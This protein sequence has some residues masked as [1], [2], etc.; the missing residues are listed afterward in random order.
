MSLKQVKAEQNLVLNG[1]SELKRSLTSL[2]HPPLEQQLHENSWSSASDSF[3]KADTFERARKNLEA[4]QGSVLERLQILRERVAT[5]KDTVLT[6]STILEGDEG[7]GN[8]YMSFFTTDGHGC[9]QPFDEVYAL[10]AKNHTRLLGVLKNLREQVVQLP[11]IVPRVT[12]KSSNKYVS[13]AVS[14]GVLE[15][16]HAVLHKLL[17]LQH[18]LSKL[19]RQPGCPVGHPDEQSSVCHDL[20]ITASPACAPYSVMVLVAALRDTGCT[21]LTSSLLHSSLDQDAVPAGLQESFRSCSVSGGG[22]LDH[23]I[24]VSM[25]WSDV[26]VPS[27]M[28]SPLHQCPIVGEANIIR[29]LCRLFPA[30]SPYHYEADVS[31]AAIAATDQLLD[32]CSTALAAVVDKRATA[33]FIGSIE[34]RLKSWRTGSS[35]FGRCGDACVWST[36]KQLSARGIKLTPSVTR[37]LT[38]HD[39]LFLVGTTQ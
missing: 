1:L 21:V 31:F 13:D 20:V 10:L 39:A 27:L 22:R 36:L 38:A 37:W 26:A 7:F 25:V 24:V 23:Q 5:L 32:S 35:E 16:H 19:I 17:L 9:Q 28:V 18:R 33:K 4:T 2:L 11:L 15:Q 34:S 14:V 8:F 29:Y 30:T 12:E 3:Q 6:H